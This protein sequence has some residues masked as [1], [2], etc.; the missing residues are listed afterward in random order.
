[1]SEDS[2]G[3]GKPRPYI[4]RN[5]SADTHNV[6]AG[7]APALQTSP[8]PQN[9]TLQ[10]FLEGLHQLGLELTEQQLDQ[11]LWYRQEL[12]D[13]NTRMNLTAIT[14][15]EEVMIKHFLDSLSLLMAFDAPEARLLDIGA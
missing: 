3:G 7:L 10:A 12:L 2:P 14:D 9:P 13:W 8:S 11:F 6:G 4:S 5:S 1:M 15:P